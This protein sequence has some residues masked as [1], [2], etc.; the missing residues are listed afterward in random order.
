[1]KKIYTVLFSLLGGL[2]LWANTIPGSFNVL[3]E[4]NAAKHGFYVQS[5]EAANLET[6]RLKDKR[7]VIHFDN[8]FDLEL[9]SAQEL[10]IQ[11]K[12]TDASIYPVDKPKGYKE[13]VMTVLDN[14]KL[15]AAVN[16]EKPVK[17]ANV[18]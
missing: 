9:L 18:N 5:I 17:K 1:M 11:G 16:T 8:G 3:N 14:G 6:F 13:P 10:F 7:V 2:S 12:L 4:T 15:V